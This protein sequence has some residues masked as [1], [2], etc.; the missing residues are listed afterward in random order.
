MIQQYGGLIGESS[1]YESLT[2]ENMVIGAVIPKSTNGYHGAVVGSSSGEHLRHNYYTGC[3]V[4]GVENATNVGNKG[5]DVQE[6]DGAV[7][8]SPIAGSGTEADPFIISSTG[9]WNLFAY[10]I[11]NGNSYSGQFVKLDADI[12][13]STIAGSKEGYPFSGTFD[14]GLHTIT[15]TITDNADYTALFRYINGATIKNLKVAGTIDGGQYAAAI[16]GAVQGTGDNTIENCVAT[17]NVVGGSHIG[18]IVGNGQA[19]NVSMTGCVYAGLMK[20]GTE[21]KGALFGWCDNGGTKTATDCLYLIQ[22]E[23]K[24]DNLDLVKGSGEVTLTNCYKTDQAEYDRAQSAPRRNRLAPKDESWDYDELYYGIWANIYD[25]MPDYLG[26]LWVDYGFLKVYDGGL[27]YEGWYIVACISLADD[28]DNNALIQLATDYI[29]D[30]TLTDRT[31]Y[32]DNAWQTL[33]LPFNLDDFAGTPLEGATVKTLVGSTY[34]ESTGT[35]TL[36]FSDNLTAIEAGKPYI[37][38]RPNGVELANPM[39]RGVVVSTEITA[40]YTN[41]ID[42]AGTYRATTFNEDNP[43]ILLLNAD[44]TLSHP[45]AGESLGSCHAYFPLKNG[46]T[47]DKLQRIVL[48]N[49]EDGTAI[50][51]VTGEQ[52]NRVV[53]YIEDGKLYIRHSD[54]TYDATGRSINR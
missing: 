28:S 46:L 22:E 15:A 51:T 44:A 7:S 16:V 33:C 35:L 42:F 18:G 37:V 45:K 34:D 19:G 1:N 9:E 20:G 27:E 11:R 39:F 52:K 17:A 5:A 8:I 40:V 3:T 38:R 32:Q 24:T 31:L 14:G 49:I 12:N 25:V 53:K 2:S 47:A 54:N 30:V 43:D 13:V 23:Q 26:K 41:H 50:E 36:D 10:N 48:N 29:V 4:A 6:N 21:A